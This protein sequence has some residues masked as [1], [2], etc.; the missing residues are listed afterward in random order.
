MKLQITSHYL[1][2]TRPAPTCPITIPK[3]GMDFRSNPT[4]VN[5][6]QLKSTTVLVSETQYSV[7]SPLSDRR[8]DLCSSNPESCEG[9]LLTALPSGLVRV[10]RFTFRTFLF[11]RF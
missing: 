7:V 1:D 8:A 4:R 5:R 11:E 2:I 9:K 6:Q 3:P 10:S